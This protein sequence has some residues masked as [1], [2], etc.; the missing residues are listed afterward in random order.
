[1]NHRETNQTNQPS[2]RAFL[3]AAGAV[4]V[5]FG[6][7]YTLF[8]RRGF[9]T[10]T[11]NLAIDRYGRLLPDPAGILDLPEGFRYRVIST[12]GTAMGE[13]LVV[14]GKPDGM[15]T[16]PGAEGKYLLIRNHELSPDKPDEGAFGEQY[17]RLS[18]IPRERFYDYG[19]GKTPCLGGTT[20]LEIDIATGN[21]ER[22]FLSLAGTSRNCA[23]GPTPWNTWISCEETVDLAING[24]E[25]MHGYCF[26][27]PADVASGIAKPEPIRGMGRFNH[28]AIAV[29]P[30][31]GCVYLTEDRPEG[32]LYRFVPN[33]PGRLLEGGRFQALAFHG[34]KGLDTR[35]WHGHN[36]V[37]RDKAYQAV[38]VDVPE[39]DSDND[40]LRHRAHAE[41]GAIFARGEG[42]WYG[43]G[44]VF[45]ACT[46][47]GAAEKGQI[48]KYTPSEFEG[49][50]GESEK[51]AN[52]VLFLEPNDGGLV[53]NCDNLTVAPWGDLV[54]CEDGSGEQ[55]LV[56]VTPQG[57]I[58]KIARNA[59]PSNS[60]FAGAVFSPDGMTLHVNIQHAGL[61]LA[62]TGPWARRALA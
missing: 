61:T 54:L 49:S 10:P 28:E 9:A 45:F 22:E 60:E 20:T 11:H 40:E 6:G 23:G 58:Y 15:A 19:G 39:P 62:I 4:S 16:F 26:E 55:F 1:M 24:N 38:W 3:K 56:G 50:P 57:E 5:G 43:N 21:V 29:D 52:I 14:P 34:A 31:S 44:A 18:A 32:A 35:N 33:A 17:D 8:A 53:D 7:M 12:A 48:F 30:K 2:R 59:H 27:V 51:P 46:N 36:L 13:G 41:G 47:G 37:E 42:I 25:K